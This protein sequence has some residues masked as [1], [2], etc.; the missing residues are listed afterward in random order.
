MLKPSQ[1]VPNL[2]FP[3]L[4]GGEF[5]LE[6]TSPEKFDLVVFYRGLHCRF[7]ISHLQELKNLMDD[8]AKNGVTIYAVSADEK[9]R[10]EEFAAKVDVPAVHFGYQLDLKIARE[11]G[12]YISSGRGKT[13]IGVVEP[14]YFNEP[15]MFLIKPDKTL[16]YGQVQT[17]P[18]ARPPFQDLLWA[19]RFS[20]EK[21]YPPRGLYQ[22]AL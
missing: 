10:A 7:C 5:D 17:M 1:R 14:D 8:Y 15:G 12:L 16:Y 21:N 20:N 3:L 13:S 18:F 9:E 22:G 4:K 2:R 6:K 19:I 11:W